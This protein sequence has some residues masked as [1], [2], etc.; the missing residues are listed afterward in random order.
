M[1]FLSGKESKKLVISY[2]WGRKICLTFLALKCF[3]L[4]YHIIHKSWWQSPMVPLWNTHP[5]RLCRDPAIAC[6]VLLP[7]SICIFSLYLADS[8]GEYCSHTVQLGEE[9]L[10]ALQEVCFPNTTKS[11]LDSLP[12]SPCFITIE[13]LVGY[14]VWPSYINALHIGI[15]MWVI[16]SELKPWL[17]LADIYTQVDVCV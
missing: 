2:Q 15:Y 12:A 13:Y 7:S 16:H 4:H 11:M 1:V 14:A 6:S 5:E 17:P 10:S 9:S 8:G 3:L